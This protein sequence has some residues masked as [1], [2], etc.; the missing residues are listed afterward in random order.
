MRYT[1]YKGLAKVKMELPHLFGYMNLKKMANWKRKNR[2]ASLLTMHNLINKWK[3]ELEIKIP[4]P[5]CLR[6]ET[7]IQIF[8]NS[9]F[10]SFLFC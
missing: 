7:R 2:H 4:N 3:S 1:Q 9:G 10:L 8:V 5:L 6:S